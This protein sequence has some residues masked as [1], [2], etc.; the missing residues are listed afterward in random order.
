VSKVVIIGAGIVGC[1]LAD[2]LTERGWTDVTVLEQGPLWAPGGSTSHAPGLVFQTNGSKT[3]A[4]FATYTVEKLMSLDLNGEPCFLQVGSIEVATTP[5]RLAELHR[6]AG[7]A[8][9]WGIPAEVITPEAAAKLHPV[10]DPNSIL[11]ALHVSTDGLAKALRADEAMGKRAISRGA[12]FLERHEVLDIKKENGKVTGVVTNQG[13]FAADVVIA[14]AGIWGPKVGDMIGMPTALQPLAHQLAWTEDI[15]S[16]ADQEEE[17]TIPLL[18]NQDHD[19]YY[20]QRGKG[21]GVGWYGHR[22]LPVKAKDIVPFDK[23]ATM[24][25]MLE[26]TAPE[27]VGAMEH[28]SEILPELKNTKITSGMNGL[29]SFTVDGNPLM[30]EW[31]GLKGFWVAEAVWVTHSA[32]VARAIAEWLV[33]GQPSITVHDC[34]VNRFEKHQLGPEHIQMRGEQNYIEVYDILHPLQP[35]EA[36]RPLRTTGFYQRQQELGGVFLEASGFERPQWYEANKNL[37][38]S[39]SIPSRNDW[40]SQYW[41]PIC[42]AEAL[43]VRE[44][45]GMFD[46]TSLKRLEVVGKGSQEFLMKMTTGN[47]DKPIGSITY[48]L[49]LAET[50]GILSDITITKLENDHFVIGA[51][52]N[53]DLIRL[54]NYA[55]DTVQVRDITSGTAVLG[56]FGPNARK[57][58]QSICED[59]L[60][61][62]SIKYFK[63]K[64]TYLGQVP[65]TLWRLSYVGELGFEV[66]VEADMALKLWDTIW[67]AGQAFELIAAGRGAFN[68]MRLEKGYR[69]FG[70]DMTTEHNPYEAGLGFAVRKTGGFIGAEALAKVNPEKLDKKLVCLKIHNNEEVVM[71][72]EP[73]IVNNEPVG[74]TTSAY[75]GHSVGH[76][77]AYA[78]L[79]ISL[80]SKGTQVSIA[81]FDKL[82]SAEV[83]A[84]PLFD[85]E[86]TRLKA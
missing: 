38:A 6:R 74:Y 29:F 78:W 31:K 11:G 10:L 22:P 21:L 35:M 15:E 7:L 80:T 86:M 46:L 76:P 30:G 77:I 5:Q 16:L 60:S 14:C 23:A 65:V 82:V 52:G 9:A 83:A 69:S 19:L 45:V 53:V 49:M 32:G 50:G 58:L 18:R 85:P 3:L 37:L 47:L 43:H 67:Q 13:D 54:Q 26:F 68:S 27:W 66:Y 33:D 79:P 51:N 17:C 61:N 20:R 25:S 48:C 44:K 81:Y 8:T 62:D 39:Y 59:D 42:G 64:Q 57:L 41:S 75:F 4:N 55:P 12:K 56:V 70:A 24:P 36:P 72:K 73:V 1:A 2:E 63:A 71:G 34:D 84:D 28:S 40:A